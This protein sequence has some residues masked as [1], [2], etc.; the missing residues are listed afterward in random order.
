MAGTGLHPWERRLDWTL[1]ALHWG[2]FTFGVIV[3]FLVGG[4]ATETTLAALIAGAYVVTLQVV[5]RRLRNRETIGELLAVVGVVASL[6]TIALTGGVDSP[7]LLYLAAPSF[8]AGAFLG[9]RIGV[10]TALLSSTGLIVVVATL[11]Q[12]VVQGQVIQVASLY[13]L[14]A[15]AFAQARRLLIEEQERSAALTEASRVSDAKARRLEAAHAALASLS[16]L[17][18]AAELNPV[19]VG[20]AAL[21]D[22]ALLVP[23]IGGIVTLNDEDGPVVV[24][25]RGSPGS[26]DERSLFPIGLGDRVLGHVALWPLPDDPLEPRRGVIE[27]V[28]GPVTLAFDN[29][30]LLRSIAGRAVQE[31]RIRLARELHDDVG[32]AL[33]SLGLGIDVAL[34]QPGTTA[35]AARHLE[36]LRRSVTSLTEDVRR[37]VADLRHDPVRSLVEQAH[38]LVGEVDGDGPSVLVD[39]DERRTPRAALAT[40]L[41]AIMTEAVRNAVE[42]A[43]A[44]SIRI[45]GTVDRDRGELIIA[46]DGG[47]FDTAAERAGH[48][49]LVGMRER[50]A[51][52]GARLAIESHPDTG[53]RVVVAWGDAT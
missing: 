18:T 25:R 43:E 40:Q 26:N 3:S 35:D 36:G 15:V 47:G 42:H 20:E 39:L 24:A 53:T 44:R 33:A 22:L 34:Q 45:E 23:F 5:P 11:G 9:F 37:T 21:R 41:T 6:I 16:E 50:A 12:E 52:A 27:E 7:Y 31:E 30:L 14:M 49:G 29:I 17:A 4:A 1:S 19:S 38:R 51:D 8:F 46:D 48:F 2:S 10:E 13:I 32:P 28:L